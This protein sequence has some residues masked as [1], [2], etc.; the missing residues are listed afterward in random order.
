MVREGGQLAWPSEI[1]CTPALSAWS[2]PII[3]SH[4]LGLLDAV[5]AATAPGGGATLCTFKTKHYQVV[6]GLDLPQPYER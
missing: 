1:D 3:I 2:P 5:I 6:P 4:G